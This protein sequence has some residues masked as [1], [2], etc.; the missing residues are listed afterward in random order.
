MRV[1]WSEQVAVLLLLL[2]CST[3]S[4]GDLG[5]TLQDDNPY[6]NLIVKVNQDLEECSI[7]LDN[8][9][10]IL[11]AASRQLNNAT[12]GKLF[13]QKVTFLLPQTLLESCRP[14]GGKVPLVKTVPEVKVQLG[15]DHPVFG[16][17]PWTQQTLGCGQP[18]HFIHLPYTFLRADSFSSPYLIRGKRVVQEWAKL[19]WGVFSEQGVAGDEVFPLAYA[20][21]A[22]RLH[23]TS[24]WLPNYCVDRDLYGEFRDPCD[25]PDCPFIL[26]DDQD[27]STSLLALYT[28]D[29]VTGF[30]D[31]TTHERLTPTKHNAQCSGRSIMEVLLDHHDFQRQPVSRDDFS[32][33]LDYVQYSTQPL[34]QYLILMDASHSGD[35]NTLQGRWS[36]ERAAV[37]QWVMMDVLT[38]SSLGI[39]TFAEY[40]HLVHN[41]TVVTDQ[42]REDI[43]NSLSQSYLDSSRDKNITYAIHTASSYMGSEGGT[44]I[45][46]VNP[47][48]VMDSA[49]AMVMAAQT[50]EVWPVL[51]T[52]T[53]L[54][55]PHITLFKD[56][57]D[58]TGGRVL[59][60]PDDPITQSGEVQQSVTVQ[61]RLVQHLRT[62][63]DHALRYTS[64]TPTLQV[65]QEQLS[66]DVSTID[67][68]LTNSTHTASLYLYTHTRPQH[69]TINSR[70]V[71]TSEVTN[72][73]FLVLL[74]DLQPGHNSIE[75]GGLS[76]EV[77]PTTPVE[78]L[79]ERSADDPEVEL[80]TSHDLTSLNLAD[81]HHPV[82][83][84][85][86]VTR[87][88]MPV[89]GA[90]VVVS[91]LEGSNK[92]DLHLY[93]NGGGSPDVTG[94]DGVYSRYWVLAPS[95]VNTYTLVVKVSSTP[96]SK[97]VGR[98]NN[99]N[100]GE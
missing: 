54:P 14:M 6:S 79:V 26:E 40:T 94:G 48:N 20:T 21:V 41:M 23:N 52:V 27:A 37:Q 13:F 69:L 5:V 89:V 42:S 65:G 1:G 3:A 49:D 73:S 93:D 15:H 72:T 31:N 19:R 86:K 62:V 28:V 96:S 76:S 25:L 78:V 35:Y 77:E 36:L 75:V 56:V 88:Q 32:I 67:I 95:G 66:S 58:R 45:L 57:A 70:P 61:H 4:S 16:G 30:C 8:F 17:Q 84:L 9:R 68:F 10:Y 82:T 38:T 46:I 43:V 39:V 81:P 83:L 2:T 12:N 24:D 51:Y 55:P 29:S 91:L 60:V 98:I 97:V 90:K 22:A 18:A 99:N 92:F 64:Y 50:S 74:Q 47:D 44:I 59:V 87:K 33:T 34:A 100:T 53:T 11:E 85:V 63:Q 71:F 7:I 80:R